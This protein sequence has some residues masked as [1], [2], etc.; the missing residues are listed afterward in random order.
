MEATPSV[1]AGRSVES[2][3]AQS[4]LAQV[5]TGRLYQER[6]SRPKD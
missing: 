1:M 3:K 2:M 4:C 5:S 6:P